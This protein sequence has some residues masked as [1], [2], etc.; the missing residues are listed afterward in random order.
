MPYYEDVFNTPE[1]SSDDWVEL[2]GPNR[3]FVDKNENI[4]VSSFRL[5]QLKSFGKDGHL[6]F[7]Y[8]KGAVGYDSE[9]FEAGVRQIFVDTM[10]HLYVAHADR[11]DYVAMLDTSGHLLARL[12]P[13]GQGSG[14]MVINIYRNSDDILSFYLEDNTFYSFSHGIFQPNGA[15]SWMA[16][17][18]FYYTG[19]QRDS[20]A[21]VI[22]K[23]KNPD[24]NGNASLESKSTLEITGAFIWYSE[25]LGVDDESQLYHFVDQYG[26]DARKVF[27]F[28]EQLEQ[29]DQVEFPLQLNRYHWEMRPFM[30]PSDG[31][32]YE[33]R[34]LDDGLHVIRWSK[35]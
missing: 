13:H 8:S 15:T 10:C 22:I 31:N 16:R 12:S 17:D 18:G 2:A 1:D 3:N 33:F 21:I 26:P 24:L 14:I 30:R 4:Y 34:C 19:Y 32:I 27:I 20:T 23:L 7:D 5:K 9:I 28:D 25:F 29:V 6:I 35:E 11:H